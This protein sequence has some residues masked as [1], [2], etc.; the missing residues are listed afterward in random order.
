MIRANC[1]IYILSPLSHVSVFLNSLVL[2]V[3]EDQSVLKILTMLLFHYVY[4]LCL[5]FHITSSHLLRQKRARS[6]VFHKVFEFTA[7]KLN[8]APIKALYNLWSVEN[9]CN[10]CLVT[11][12]CLSVNHESVGS[13]R[14]ELL[15]EDR[16]TRG[17]SDFE[18]AEYFS[19]Y[20]TVSWIQNSA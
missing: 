20:D 4:A 8:I 18:P 3:L 16:N 15:A 10:N 1:F 14:C 6:A 19:Y 12:G 17:K 11:K 9:C 7:K 13:R 2:K 5:Y